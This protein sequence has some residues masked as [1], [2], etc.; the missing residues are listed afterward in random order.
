MATSFF[1]DASFVTGCAILGDGA[2]LYLKDV[3]SD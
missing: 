2:A 1:A 3:W